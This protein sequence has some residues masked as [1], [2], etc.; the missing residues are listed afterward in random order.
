MIGALRVRGWE[1]GEGKGEGQGRG[2]EAE[3][4]MIL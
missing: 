2:G 3:D 1:K 4:W